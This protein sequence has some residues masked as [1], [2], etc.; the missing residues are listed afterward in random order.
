MF[1]KLNGELKEKAMDKRDE[2]AA[3]LTLVS[4]GVLAVVGIGLFRILK[5][6]GHTDRAKSFQ[7]RRQQRYRYL[8]RNAGEN[9]ATVPFMVQNQNNARTITITTNQTYVCS[10]T[11][12]L[13]MKSS[14]GVTTATGI[15]G[16]TIRRFWFPTSPH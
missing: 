10:V 15:A 6:S 5:S 2:D 1:L 9:T 8:R 13:A 12:V 7:P 14:D 16:M 11:R 3:I 4:L